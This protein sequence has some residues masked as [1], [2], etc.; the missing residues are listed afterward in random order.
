MSKKRQKSEEEILREFGYETTPRPF[1]D[2]IEKYLTDGEK[3][4]TLLF[5]VSEGIEQELPQVANIAV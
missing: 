1:W 4:D 5:R 2:D 3:Y